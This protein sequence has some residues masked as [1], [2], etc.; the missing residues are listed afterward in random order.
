MLCWTSTY[1]LYLSV[2]SP[3]HVLVLIINTPEPD[4]AGLKQNKIKLREEIWASKNV[5]ME[6]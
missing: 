4:D 3:T 2:S 5:F 1:F 6:I